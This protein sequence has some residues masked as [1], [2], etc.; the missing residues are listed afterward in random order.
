[1]A[2]GGQV[3]PEVWGL[4]VTLSQDFPCSRS[5]AREGTGGEGRAGE[6]RAGWAGVPTAWGSHVHGSVWFGLPG[7]RAGSASGLGGRVW[8]VWFDLAVRCWGRGG[9]QSYSHYTPREARKGG[10]GAGQRPGGDAAR[11]RLFMSCLPALF[12]F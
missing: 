8:A 10:A 7:S 12:Y 3:G 11:A 4:G 1:M 5:P 2:F 9:R 6:G